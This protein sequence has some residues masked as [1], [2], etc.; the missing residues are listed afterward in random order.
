MCSVLPMHC[1][2]TLPSGRSR[3]AP[4][5]PRWSL[6]FPHWCGTEWLPGIPSLGAWAGLCFWSPQVILHDSQLLCYHPSCLRNPHAQVFPS[7][8]HI[9]VLCISVFLSSSLTLAPTLPYP[10]PENPPKQANKQKTRIFYNIKLGW[11]S[12]NPPVSVF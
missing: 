7:G 8:Y 2:A 5:I 6:Q 11:N 4:F 10:P 9:S 3:P 1:L 12:S